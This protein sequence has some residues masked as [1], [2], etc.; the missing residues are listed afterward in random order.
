MPKSRILL[1]VVAALVVVAAVAAFLLARNLDHLVAA[2]IEKYGSAAAGTPVRVTGVEIGLQAG[3]GTVRQLTVANPPGFAGEPAFRL[4]EITLDLDPRSLTT[5]LPVVEEIRVIAPILFFEIDR[6]GRT[7][8]SVIR[9]NLDRYSRAHEGG[10]QAPAAGESAPPRLRVL[11]LTVEGGTGILD[12]T[13]VGD[14]RREIRLPAITLTDIGGRSGVT[15]GQL[16]ERVLAA[17]LQQLEQAAARQGVERAIRGR[18]QEESGEMQKKL[19]EKA[20]E[21]LKGIFGR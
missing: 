9:K 21:A 8:V 2:A 1:L 10:S 19:E 12:L 20:G 16:G 4:G 18:V 17:L 6:Q 14:R 13:A 11:R 3:R 5:E 15:P 7:N